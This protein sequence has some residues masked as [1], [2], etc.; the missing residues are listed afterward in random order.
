MDR[1]HT[2][3]LLSD[4]TA[5]DAVAGGS[6]ASSRHRYGFDARSVRGARLQKKLLDAA[7]VLIDGGNL[8][9]SLTDITA[10]AGVRPNCINEQFG[11]LHLLFRQL[12]R[13]RPVDVLVAL[14]LPGDLPEAERIELAWMI[15]TG[16][17]PEKLGGRS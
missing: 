14:R 8:R 1:A 13:E 3:A 17:R 12:V 6:A 7:L 16:S 11:Y 15:L 9:P 2:I 5:A 10:W 4:S